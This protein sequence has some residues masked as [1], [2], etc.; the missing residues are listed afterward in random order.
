MLIHQL[1]RGQETSLRSQGKFIIS[2][3][4]TLEGGC[5]NFPAGLVLKR[6]SGLRDYLG[7]RCVP[8]Q[9]VSLDLQS[10]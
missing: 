7:V 1:L 4:T 8:A 6:G 3:E 5:I 9:Y 10:L 2:F